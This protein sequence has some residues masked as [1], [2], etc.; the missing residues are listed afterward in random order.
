MTGRAD[1]IRSRVR[2]WTRLAR[3]IA[4]IR[5]DLP[6]AGLDCVLTAAAYTAALFLRVEG[7]VPQRF[8]VGF[9]TFLPL[10]VGVHLLS[11]W[12]W[13]LYGRMWRHASVQEARRVLVAAATAGAVLLAAAATV[14]LAP[15][16]LPL[17]GAAL[18]LLL[19]GGVR[20]QSR[21]FALRRGADRRRSTRV[22]VVGAGESGGAIVR[23]MLRTPEEQLLPVAVLDDDPSK[24][25]RSLVGV[26]VIGGIG[27]LHDAARVHGADA[28]LLA[29]PSADAALV[30]RVARIADHAGLPLK[31]LPSV[32][33]L[34][35]GR[36]SVRD[37]RDVEI[38]D[39][40][41]RAQVSTDLEAVRELLRGQRI[42]ITGGGGSIGSEIARQVAAFD[43]ACLVLLDRDESH[44]HEAAVTLDDSV[45][46][47]ADICDMAAL[48]RA[49]ETHRPDIVFHAAAL[50][51]VPV[52]ERHPCAAV[53]TNVL[54]TS[55]VITAA[56]QHAVG[57]LVV[58]STDK[59]VEPCG[60]M[61]ASKRLCEQLVLHGAGP[62][63]RYCAVRFGNV[64]GSRGSV[65][66]TFMRQ[67][68]DG[69]P[70]TVTDARMTRY[71]MTVAEAV[72][73]VLQAGVYCEGGEIF[74]LRMGEPVRILDLAERMIRLSGRQ[75]GTDVPVR[76]TGRRPGEKLAERLHATG[77]DPEPTAHPSILVVHP[78]TL[79]RA[80]LTAGLVELSE[81][82]RRHDR[83]ATRQTLLNLAAAEPV[84]RL[85]EHA[86]P[87]PDTRHRLVG[88][89]GR[90][91][92]T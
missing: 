64:L 27:A 33:E 11:N 34:V 46:V 59:A 14:H 3:A 51:H 61:G 55:N 68:A 26:P 47:L 7:D 17:F 81:A 5:S 28:A 79:P 49:F 73:L 12:A 84:I 54:G 92:G 62:D 18:T 9:R 75:V 2:L 6:L 8:L 53:R 91:A 21:L 50:K 80:A 86:R 85:P 48:E 69:G 13:G 32:R 16:S 74:T 23:E 37:V 63:R 90:K 1:P 67:I 56:R 38:T 76:I 58:I 15:R 66:P 29:I 44:L 25:G 19:A 42:M 87:I 30:R 57:R 78:R 60:V 83:A 45:Q 35:G 52:L 65:V 22:V 39:L 4:R 77:E 20:F 36:V 82:A 40:L 70:V 43:P 41:G 71:F 24:Q 89:T 10:A 72:Q 88:D 31:V